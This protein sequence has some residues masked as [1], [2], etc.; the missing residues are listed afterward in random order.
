CIAEAQACGDISD[1]IDAATTAG[2]IID[3]WEGAIMHMKLCNSKQ[4]LEI[5]KQHVFDFILARES[6]RETRQ[7]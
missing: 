4:P 5:F 7:E 6:N 3:S 2:F 1:T